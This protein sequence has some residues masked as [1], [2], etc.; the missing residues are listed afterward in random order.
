MPDP[1]LDSKISEA[2]VTAT[3]RGPPIAGRPTHHRRLASRGAGHIPPKASRPAM[4]SMTTATTP[5]RICQ[6][7][8][9]AKNRVRARAP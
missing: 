5:S 4:T 3:Q 9:V 6:E 2:F 1:A 7:R 8:G